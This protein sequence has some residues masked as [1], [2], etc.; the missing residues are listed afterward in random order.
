MTLLRFFV[1]SFL[2]GILLA[3]AWVPHGFTP[4]IFIAFIPLLYVESELV[5]SLKS[6]KWLMVIGAYVTFFVW[7]LLTTWWMTNASMEG[8]A[9]A[10]ACNSMFMTVVFMLA[11][12]AKNRI[13]DWWSGVI[14]ISFWMSFEL[15]HHRWDLDDPWLTLGNV[16]AAHVNWVQ[17]YEYTGVLGGSFWVLFFNASLF[18]AL[19]NK[20][21]DFVQ[22]VKSKSALRHTLYII[23]PI[24]VSYYI[25][26]S[27]VPDRGVP[28][29]VIVVQPNVDPYNEKFSASHQQQLNKMLSLA[30]EKLGDSTDYVVFPET[31][32]TEYMWERGIEN[33]S[34]IRSIRAFLDTLPNL[35]FITGAS[36]AKIFEEG[37]PLSSTARKFKQ[38]DMYY[39]SYNTALQLK[40][41]MPLQLY[42]KSKLVAGVEKMPLQ[43]IFKYL[44][45]FTIDLGG[46]S[47][48]LGIQEERTVLYDSTKGIG[49]APVICY[50]SVFGEHVSDYIKNGA[51]F[52]SLI[53]NDGWWGD[54]PGYKQH[55][56]YGSLRAIETRRWIA[57]SANTGTSCFVDPFGII[58]KATEY[59]QE[60]VISHTIYSN[61]RITFYTKY[62]DLIGWVFVPI[63]LLLLLYSQLIRFRVIKK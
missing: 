53:T 12:R 47:G 58:I 34:S 36:T 42:H 54:T 40:K 35:N 61:N 9:F 3:L 60:A 5:A 48:S 33:A 56:A 43:F 10:I 23:I 24:S 19:K 52:I 30:S 15:L 49:T 41:G 62:G 32:L 14:F 6:G 63:S 55:L 11:H 21:F 8:G 27:I 39:D 1:L 17:W 18:K 13:G 7:N 57:R 59:W 38:A 44:E 22:F 51:G 29:N 28:I 20:R 2:S 37:E 16:F 26:H 25:Q 50:E 31:A 4:L 45:N 46:I